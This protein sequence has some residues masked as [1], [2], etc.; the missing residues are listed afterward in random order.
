MVVAGSLALQGAL[1]MQCCCDL[2]AWLGA[3]CALQF[4][5]CEVLT[6][7]C[8]AFDGAY[9]AQGVEEGK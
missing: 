4:W 3:Q 7:G 9:A 2:F 5:L 6:A 1:R 8:I